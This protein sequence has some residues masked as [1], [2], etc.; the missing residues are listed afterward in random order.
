MLVPAERPLVRRAVGPLT[1]GS[2]LAGLAMVLAQ[3]LVLVCIPQ[4][5]GQ[6]RKGYLGREVAARRDGGQPVPT[7]LAWVVHSVVAE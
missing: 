2:L 1:T 3:R 4:A 5:G 6:S 7:A